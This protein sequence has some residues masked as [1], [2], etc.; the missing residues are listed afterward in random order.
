M[1]TGTVTGTATTFKGPK[2]LLPAEVVRTLPGYRV[3]FPVT[4]D[5]PVYTKII[6]NATVLIHTTSVATIHIYQ[7]GNYTCVATS[8]YGTDVREFSVI[9]KDCVP[10]CSYDFNPYYGNTLSCTNVSLAMD[11]MNCLPTM[12]ETLKVSSSNLTHIPAGMFSNLTNL[13][14]LDLS[15]NAIKLLPDG[16]FA[17]LINLTYLNLSSNSIKFLP[18]KV[19]SKLKKLLFLNLA[20]NN[21]TVLPEKLF[22]ELKDLTYLNMAFN[23]ITVLPEKVFNDQKVL[24]YLNLASNNITVLPEK[25]FNELKALKTLDLSSNAIVNIS[26]HCAILFRPFYKLK[27]LNLS[28]NALQKLHLC[29]S[30]RKLQT[31]D[32]SSNA[33]TNPYFQCGRYTCNPYY[34]V[35]YLDWSSNGIKTL[36]NQVFKT[37]RQ[38]QILDLSFN[39]ITFLPVEVFQKLT[40]LRILSLAS[41]AITFL[42]NRMFARLRELMVLDLSSNAITVL[43]SGVFTSLKRQLTCLMLSDNPIKTIEPGAFK[44]YYYGKQLR[45]FLLRT[46]IKKLSIDVFSAYRLQDFK[47]VVWN[48]IPGLM[49]I[50]YYY[51]R[52]NVK[53][54]LSPVN[55]STEA[56]KVDLKDFYSEWYIVSMLA[57]GF[58]Q[59]PDKNPNIASFLPCPLGTFSNSSSRGKQGCIECPPG[60]FYADA[61]AYVARSCKS[62]PNGSYVSFDRAPGKSVLDCKAC[63]QGTETDFFAGY[64]ACQCLEGFYRTHLF[65]ECHKCGQGG[66]LCQNDYASLKSG[67]WWQWRNETYK[68]RYIYFIK[69]ALAT[70]PLLDDFSVKYPYPIPTPYKCPIDGSCKGGLDSPCEKGYEGP[71][72]AVCSPGYYKQLQ[73]CSQCPSKKWIVG[74]LSVICAIFLILVVLLVWKSK[75][76]AKKSGGTHL[77][78]TFFSKLKI[79]IGFYQVTHGLLEVFSYIKWPDS[80]EDFAKYSGILQMN[81]LQIAPVHCLFPGI[82]MDAFGELCLIMAINAS[83]MGASGIVYGFR[84]VMILR[85]RSLED[86]EKSNKISEIKELLYRNL[87]F[88]LYVSYLSTCSKTASVMPFACH[89]LCRDKEE[90][91]CNEYLKGDYHVQCQ[92]EKYRHWL[93]VAYISTVYILALPVASFI[94]LWREQRVILTTPGGD[95]G[96][97]PELIT[98]LCFLFENYKPRSWYWELVEMSRKVVLTSVLILVGQES[99]SYIG[100]AWVVAGMYGVLF[101]WIKPTQDSFDNRLMSTSLAVTVLNLGIGA[102]SR[103]PAENLPESTDRYT[104]AVALKILI[105]GANTMVIG[106]LAVQYLVHLYN[107]FKEWRKNPQ[108]SFSCCLDFLLTLNDLQGE[109]CGLSGKNILNSQLQTGNMEMPCIATSSKKRNLG[110][111]KTTVLQ[112]RNWKGFKYSN[113]KC[114]QGT[115]TDVFTLPMAPT[116][117]RKSLEGTQEIYI[118]AL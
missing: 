53:I 99:R 1:T 31:L 105:M 55:S 76:K 88:F 30:N 109:V 113:R 54:Y 118:T 22:N 108:W 104:D 86:E 19:F 101:S 84:K 3:T 41:N 66:L 97:S 18:E 5:W 56:V 16:V 67:H 69:N 107:V 40:A 72:C 95:A 32:L 116:V 65:S 102:V 80:L 45:I 64:R 81:L 37:L 20:S 60:G 27:Y 98:G 57:S 111:D 92:G 23:N 42:H 106:L 78:D 12:T 9:F 91:L 79:A 87:F 49:K 48:R 28:S 94:A 35:N 93:I 47:L 38:L 59:V 10:Q 43:P 83:L 63:P 85:N 74:Q 11:V 73:S 6:R 62:C 103:I 39:A 82:H 33:I 24:K 7:E 115:Q 26:F 110:D 68:H 44:V 71:L 51:S 58:R 46:N 8:K 13:L 70:L 21:I 36:P 25:V 89:K 90:E 117:V 2:I 96:S 114:H 112:K 17:D 61:L 50:K 14:H 75:R 52:Q 29:P 4:G 77:I 15:Y 100:L 34:D